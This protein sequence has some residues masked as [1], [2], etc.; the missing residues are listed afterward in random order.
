MPLR[1]GAGE[2][3]PALF[4]HGVVRVVP[5]V[6]GVEVLAAALQGAELHGAEG[7][8]QGTEGLAGPVVELPGG[9]VKA[10]PGGK[11]VIAYAG[12]LSEAVEAAAVAHEKLGGLGDG[13]EQQLPVLRRAVGQ[14]AGHEVGQLLLR[15]PVV[16]VHQVLLPQGRG[17]ADVAGEEVRHLL[18]VA[19]V[20]GLLQ[21]AADLGGAGE[22][23]HLHPDALLLPH[24][25]VEL[26]H[27]NVHGG[28]GLLAVD[29]PEVDRDRVVFVQQRLLSAAGEGQEKG[30]QQQQGQHALFH[31]QDL[32]K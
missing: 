29:V 19:A 4:E 12:G 28:A 18:Q 14:K 6:L 31:G 3:H 25:V 5:A 7:V 24:G 2:L 17:V 21:K 22:V 15:E 23:R 10:L 30:C 13:K 8:V 16:P 1:Q 32:Q 9:I 26:L 11:L 27:Q 20:L